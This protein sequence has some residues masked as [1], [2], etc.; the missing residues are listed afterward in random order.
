MEAA[1]HV[2]HPA[3]NGHEYELL[4]RAGKIGAEVYRFK[5]DYYAVT[6]ST[7]HRVLPNF[8]RDLQGQIVMVEV[9]LGN[10]DE[11]WWVEKLGKCGFV[12]NEHLTAQVREG[13][14]WKDVWVCVQP[15][16]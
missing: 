9:G 8:A 14:E 2:M 7:A 15:S 1:R 16:S 12:V 5:A 13:T 10:K 4:T 3:S 6:P 11:A